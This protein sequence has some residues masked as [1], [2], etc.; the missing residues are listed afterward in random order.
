M[1]ESALAHAVWRMD[2]ALTGGEEPSRAADKVLAALECFAA[3]GGNL[4]TIQKPTAWI[5]HTQ[6]IQAVSTDLQSFRQ[7]L[8]PRPEVLFLTS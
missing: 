3:L 4:R 1:A 5:P 8:S 7:A 6:G 2:A